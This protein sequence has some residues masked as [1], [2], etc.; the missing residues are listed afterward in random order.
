MNKDLEILPSRVGDIDEISDLYDLVNEY[1][2][3]HTNYPGWKKGIYPA[4]IDAQEGIGKGTLYV[5][6]LSG[7][8]A[9]SVIVNQKQENGYDTVS[10]RLVAD[11]EKVAVIHTL[12]V[13]PDFQ[14]SGIAKALLEFSEKKALE[15]GRKTIRLDVYENNEPAIRLYEQMGYQYA[16]IADLGYGA[17]GLDWFKLYEKPLKGRDPDDE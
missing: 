3:S 12:L 14:K 8:I 4:R 7:R 15:E 10:W 5:A 11:P 6:R 2:E 17:Y 1:L 9:G 13:H 16:G